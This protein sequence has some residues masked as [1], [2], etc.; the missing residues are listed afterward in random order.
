MSRPRQNRA[1]RRN[2]RLSKGPKTPEG[3]ARSAKNALKHGLLARGVLLPDE[4]AEA[5]SELSRRFIEDLKPVGALELFLVKRVIGQCWRLER[6]CK[7]EGGHVRLAPGG[8]GGE[9]L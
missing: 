1:N 5:F 9:A 6:L 7:F 8:L 4:D 3:K 2:S